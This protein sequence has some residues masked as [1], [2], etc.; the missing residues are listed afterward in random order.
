[1][2]RLAQGQGPV[3]AVEAVRAGTPPERLA[4]DLKLGIGQ[5]RSVPGRAGAARACDPPARHSAYQRLTFCRATP[6]W[7]VTS[8]WERPAANSSPACRR[9]RSKP[10]GHA[11]RGRCGGRRLVSS[12]QAARTTPV[13]SSEGANVFKCSAGARPGS[14]ML[15]YAS[16]GGHSHGYPLCGC[17]QIRIWQ[18]GARS[19]RVPCK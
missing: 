14:H 15:Q 17:S 5:A 6:S 18:A 4:D 19:C 11:D 16:N 8:A 7:R 13:M 1:V 9:T 3:V 10:G 2:S 12:R